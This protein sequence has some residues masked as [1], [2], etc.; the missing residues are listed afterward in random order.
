MFFQTKHNYCI[1]ES[2]CI[3]EEMLACLKEIN[4]L[5]SFPSNEDNKENKHDFKT[6]HILLTKICETRFTF[7][8]KSLHSQKMNNKIIQMMIYLI[9][10]V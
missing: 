5:H 6:I 2:I 8:K 10:M 9:I 7:I 4:D 1:K 3:L